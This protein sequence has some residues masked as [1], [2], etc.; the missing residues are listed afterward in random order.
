MNISV[1]IVILNIIIDL[2]LIIIVIIIEN[3]HHSDPQLHHWHHYITICAQNLLISILIC[4][5]GR[6]QAP[7]AAKIVSRGARSKSSI[8]IGRQQIPAI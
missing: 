2:W 6:S 8:L 3:I 4:L 5:E 1:L 7:R